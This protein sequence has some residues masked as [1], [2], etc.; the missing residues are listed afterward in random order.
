[1]RDELVLL[2]SSI[3]VRHL[4]RSGPTKI[5]RA[6][7]EA[8]VQRS[9]ATCWV[10]KAELLAGARDSPASDALL[11]ALQGVPEIPITE[12]IWLAAAR[13]GQ[14]LRRQGLTI[15]L[16][17]LLIAQC[18]ISSNRVLWHVDQHFEWIRQHGSLE[19]RY[20]KLED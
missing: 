12:A 10:V 3:W 4:R 9:V 17:D 2:D 13:L 11:D 6:V 20:W 8:L 7:R 5:K 15:A 18:A 16:P 14:A 1:M 19:T